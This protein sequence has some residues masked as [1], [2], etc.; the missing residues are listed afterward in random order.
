MPQS[1]F[2]P[3]PGTARVATPFVKWAGGKAK[4]LPEIVARAPLNIAHYHEPFVGGGGVFFG[5]QAAGRVSLATL[6]DANAQLIGAYE[7]VRDR[8]NDLVAALDVHA[9]AYKRDSEA[10]AAYYYAV[11]GCSSVSPVERAARLIF[12][13]R[14]CYNGLYRE[15]RKGAF[16]VPHGRYANPRIVDE[17]GLAA[18]SA[19]LQKA[20]LTCRDFEAAMIRAQPGDFVYLDP[21]YVPLSATSSFTSYTGA[22]FGW[23]DQERLARAFADLTRRGVA[24][25][26]SNSAVPAVESLYEGYQLAHVPMSRSINSAAARRAPIPELLVSNRF[27]L[28]RR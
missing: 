4:L 17:A 20:E 26:L 9:R 18:C 11:R 25:L 6:N 23:P 24:A 14:T 15:N 1:S 16:N 2:W 27:R 28:A 3:Q 21:P 5:L 19:A 12:L 7:V 10:R 22:D 13:N 8:P